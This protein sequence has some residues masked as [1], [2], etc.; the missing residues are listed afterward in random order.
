VKRH[1]RKKNIFHIFLSLQPL[2][3]FSCPGG[4][5]AMKRLKRKKNMENVF[6]RLCRFTPLQLHF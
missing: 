3:R 2:H 1:K 4:A 5:E 6:L